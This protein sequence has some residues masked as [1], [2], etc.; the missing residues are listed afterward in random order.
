[1]Q[2]ILLWVGLTTKYD[3]GSCTDAIFSKQSLL[4]ISFCFYVLLLRYTTSL[5]DSWVKYIIFSGNYNILLSAE[6]AAG[7]QCGHGDLFCGNTISAWL[8][9]DSGGIKNGYNR[10]VAISVDYWF[11]PV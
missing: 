10:E 9:V 7:W 4:T 6:A 5:T 3:S 1:M 11:N 8:V 2:T